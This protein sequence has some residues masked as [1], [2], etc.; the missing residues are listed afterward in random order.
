MKLLDL[1]DKATLF[2]SKG[3]ILSLFCV[4]RRK[5]DR[6]AVSALSF[7][8]ILSTVTCRLPLFFGRWA[9]TVFSA[10]S[11]SSFSPGSWMIGSVSQ[12]TFMTLVVLSANSNICERSCSHYLIL[13]FITNGVDLW[14]CRVVLTS[15]KITR[16]ASG[17]KC[18]K[19]RLFH[20][21]S[22]P[23]LLLWEPFVTTTHNFTTVVVVDLRGLQFDLSRTSAAARETIISK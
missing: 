6:W 2:L 12:D 23:S 8:R 16:P 14:D 20:Q 9:K 1:L 15:R 10:S 4:I 3:P 7:G 18:E 17:T 5:L 11:S 19:V 13:P 21:F 22:L